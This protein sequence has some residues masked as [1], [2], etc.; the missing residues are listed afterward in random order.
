M[1]SFTEPCL[2]A[3]LL[4]P[5]VEH[6]DETVLGAMKLLRYP[7]MA[8][9]KKDGIRALRL[10]GTLLSRRFKKIPNQRVCERGQVLPAG[11]DSELF[12][13][14]LD[15]NTIQSI[16]MSREHVHWD[17]IQVHVLDWFIPDAPTI[18]YEERCKRI[19]EWIAE[20]EV[21]AGMVFFDKPIVCYTAEE[22]F[23][24][25]KMC[26]DKLGEGICFR[27]PNSPYKFGR[28]TLGEQWLIKLCRFVRDEAVVIGF[29]EQMANGNPD[30]WG[31][32]G[33][34]DRSHSLDGLIPKGTLGAFIVRNSAG[35]VFTIGTGVGLG[36]KWRQYIW[37]NQ[38]EFLY[39]TMTYKCKAHGAKLLPRSPVF[40][41]WRKDGE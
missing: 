12:N 37:E 30:N 39:K 7:V 14:E 17:K 24:F 6:T 23:E 33:K 15:Y 4:D 38:T 25:E 26:M 11:F 31:A 13:S 36:N 40:V 34:M 3:P 8:T 18:G 22:L 5:E 2:A 10:N 35:Q 20:A 27:T 9:L 1:T 32:T 21:P 41:G 29:K 28:S 16:V 19:E